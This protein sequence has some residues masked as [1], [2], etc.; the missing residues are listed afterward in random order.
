MKLSFPLGLALLVSLLCGPALAQEAGGQNGGSP[1]WSA[2]TRADLDA[3]ADLIR[4]NHPAMVPEV[5]DTGFTARFD[6]SLAK[7]EARVPQVVDADGL[8]ATL[9]GFA[10]GL[11]DDHIVWAPKSGLPVKAWPGFMVVRRG[12]DLVVT[13]TGPD[14]PPTGARLLACDGVPADALLLQRTADRVPDPDI[15]AQLVLNSIWVVLDDGNPFIPRPRQCRFDAEARA[16]DVTLSYRPVTAE[17]FARIRDGRRL[18]GRAGFGVRAVGDARWIA[19]QSFG[20]EA[21]AVV[22]AARARQAELR[23]AP[24]VVIDLRGN[25]GGNSRYG[26]QLAEIVLGEEPLR[27]LD[28]ATSGVTCPAVWR[29][30]P[31]NRR[32]LD[33]YAERFPD[34]ADYWRSEAAAMD[35]ALAAGRPLTGSIAGCQVETRPAAP[36]PHPLFAGTL[37]VVTDAA[38]FSSCTLVVGRLRALGAIQV[39]AATNAPTRYMEVR[40]I[41]L[42]SGLGGFSTLQKA[43]MASPPLVGPFAPDIPYA[44]D[45]A[46]TAALEAWLPAAIE[47]R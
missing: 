35:A 32:T 4:D 44:G 23:A 46:D 19:V 12:G 24:L 16:V 6:A 42:P 26:D 1:D 34:S 13:T 30:S 33:L 18:V 3:A 38:C 5:G 27:A 28:A 39:G 36:P 41:D 20:D 45:I 17:D 21:P 7:A 22:E 29:A 15:A 25:G 40:S 9:R 8:A 37:V 2:L 11:G 14:G 43:A 47:G 31:G 10:S